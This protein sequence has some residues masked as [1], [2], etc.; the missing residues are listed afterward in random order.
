MAIKHGSTNITIVKHGTAS[1]STV[2][3]GGTKVFPDA[4]YQ[5]LNIYASRDYDE[6]TGW[7]AFLRIENPN[8]FDVNI[9]VSYLYVNTSSDT[10]ERE[11]YELGSVDSNNMVWFYLYYT[12]AEIYDFNIDLQIEGDIYAWD[13]SA[14]W[15]D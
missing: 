1:I 4:T 15:S 10:Y 11:D 7:Y 12:E 6:D 14:G 5:E 8:S 3:H 9:T 13:Q 2:Y